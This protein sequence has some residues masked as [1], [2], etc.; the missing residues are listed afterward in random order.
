[1]GQ[2]AGQHRTHWIGGKPWTAPVGSARRHLQ[3]GDRPGQRHGGLRHRGRGRRR[4][5]GGRRRVPGLAGDL[6]GQAGRRSCSRSASWSAPAPGRAGRAD[7]APSTARSLSDARGEVARGL[8]VVEFACGIPHLLKGGVLRERLDRRR[9]VLDPPAARRGRR[10]HPVQLPG[11]G[12]DVDVPD[13]DR[14]RQH[15][16]CSS[17]R[18]RT[19]RRRCCIAELLA[20]AG[21]PDGVFNVVHGDKEAVDALLTHPEVKAV[22]FVGSTPIARYVYETGTAA[23]Q[24]GPGPRRREEPHGRAARRRPRPG[25]R[26]RG[27]RRLRLG[28]RALHG[29]LGPG[30]RRPGRRR[31]GRQDRRAGREA[32][33]RPRRPTRRPRWARWS[34]GRTATRSPSYLDAGVADGADARRRRPRAPGHRRRGRRLLARPEPARPRHARR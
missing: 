13:R 22:S 9:R 3:P 14:L 32:A 7:H 5:R 24:A 23:R 20:E 10:D 30:R 17:R 21:L 4:G 8:E 26:R 15:R 1:M 6:A 25:R 33:D 31:A 28:R 18:R 2:T 19:R 34:P 11:H 16:S 29:D 12:A 27:L